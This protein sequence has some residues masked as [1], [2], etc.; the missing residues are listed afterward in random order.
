MPAHDALTRSSLTG[1]RE[2]LRERVRRDQ[3]MADRR[4]A[5][6]DSPSWRARLD[7][8]KAQMED[9][10]LKV[11]MAE[12]EMRRAVATMRDEQR[13]SGQQ[14]NMRQRSLADMQELI[15]GLREEQQMAK[16]AL[17]GCQTALRQ[18]RGVAALQIYCGWERHLCYRALRL[19]Y[20]MA[21]G[22][23]AGELRSE[24]GR[25]EDEARAER[26]ERNRTDEQLRGSSYEVE[27]ERIRADALT[28]RVEELQG[29]LARRTQSLAAE[30]E[31]SRERYL[32]ELRAEHALYVASLQ[33]EHEQATRRTWRKAQRAQDAA[34]QLL[35]RAHERRLLGICWLAL[36]QNVLHNQAEG[37]VLQE[38]REQIEENARERSELLERLSAAEATAQA[39]VAA[40]AA[41]Q[42]AAKA[43]AEA[44]ATERQRLTRQSEASMV[45]AEEERA[46]AKLTTESL[47]TETQAELD[48]YKSDSEAKSAEISLLNATL[49]AYKKQLDELTSQLTHQQ[50]LSRQAALD[51]QAAQ[52][53]AD[54]QR[55]QIK[56]V[57]AAR[58]LPA[59]ESA[60]AASASSSGPLAPLTGTLGEPLP[61]N[62][63]SGPYSYLTEG[64]R[65]ISESRNRLAMADQELAKSDR[66]LVDLSEE[67]DRSESARIDLQ[68]HRPVARPQAPHARHIPPATTCTPLHPLPCLY[69]PTSYAH[70]RAST[71]RS[72]SALARDQS[73]SSSNLSHR[74]ISLVVTCAGGRREAGDRAGG[75]RG[76]RAGVRT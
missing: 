18:A 49:E 76:A 28:A 1:W 7:A 32:G 6:V 8:V 71:D 57:A 13:V 34:L 19:W 42:D 15:H 64:R 33:E 62:P 70:Y 72:E 29:A 43:A 17:H 67:L 46:R 39:A 24:V 52:A 66:A 40:H 12:Q 51:A 61:A 31:A 69:F 11:E 41:S 22:L 45:A 36:R 9:S 21:A 50:A 55:A 37:R 10:S 47:R 5:S 30:A 75:G 58:G 20:A 53:D 26:M 73:L 68:V 25:L 48:R 59:A 4:L 23:T 63:A 16:A 65:V 14:A 74:P 3:E 35:P 44:Y 2:E 38:H 54:A 56:A 60:L 27:E